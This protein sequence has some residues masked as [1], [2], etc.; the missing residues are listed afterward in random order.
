M[1]NKNITL[2][3]L[4]I[5]DEK[6]IGLQFYPN[7]VIQNILGTIKEL[8]YS[9]AFGM[10]YLP[11]TG[12][13]VQQIFTLFK[14]VAWVNGQY[15]F[16]RTRNTENKPIRLS[17]YA[18]QNRPEGYKRCPETYIQK[19]EVMRYSLN[20]AKS[21]MSCFEKFINHYKDL[22]VEEI[23]EN[24][25]HNY[26][27][28]LVQ[29]GKSDST[30]NVAVNAIKFYYE[31]VLGMPNRFYSINRPLKR[32]KLP[33][34]ISKAEIKSIIEH[35][36]NLKHKCVVSLLYSAGLRRNELIQLKPEDI[37]SKRMVILVNEGKG[38]KQ[39]LTILSPVIL[40]DLRLYFKEWRPRHFLFE[41]A[42]GGA[43]S[44]TSVLNIVKNAAKRAGISK[45]ITPHILRHSFATHLLE[46]GIDLR[47]IQSLLGHSSTKTTEVYTQVAT[48]NIINIISPLDEL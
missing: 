22:N 1:N 12:Y 19:L 11:N 16:N 2:K 8:K 10:Y 36:T 32:E 31:G 34:V 14:G 39:R 4:L 30:L 35:T 6:K 23:D 33:K 26:L 42:K 25:V 41:G 24:D 21:Y 5:D 20:T 17:D 37:D 13:F 45:P 9:K 28:L 29:Q 15:F 48:K 44:S 3:H 27:Q 43:Y 18:K 38:K 40:K 7:L 46:D 47:Y